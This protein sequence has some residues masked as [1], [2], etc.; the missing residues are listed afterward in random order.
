VTKHAELT[1]DWV[2]GSEVP[3]ERGQL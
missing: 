3:R 1:W 2:Y